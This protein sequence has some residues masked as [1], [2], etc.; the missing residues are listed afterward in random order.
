MEPTD[1]RLALLRIQ[2]FTAMQALKGDDL[3]EFWELIEEVMQCSFTY[4]LLNNE[5]AYQ[6][7]LEQ[8]RPLWHKLNR[9]MEDMKKG[10]EIFDKVL[11]PEGRL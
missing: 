11:G 6:R 8:L 7:A 3:R 4:N 10:Q 2:L 1:M 5:R 9:T